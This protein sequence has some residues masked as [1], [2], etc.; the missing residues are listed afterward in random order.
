MKIFA[1]CLA[2]LLALISLAAAGLGIYIS[3]DKRGDLPFLVQ[4][5]PLAR[6]RV[7]TLFSSVK[8]G[9]YILAE[10]VILGQPSLGIDRPAKDPLAAAVWDAYQNSLKFEPLSDF[11]ATTY[12]LAVDYKMSRLDVTSVLEPVA[13]RAEANIQQRIAQAKSVEEI[14]DS[15]NEY[16]D[17]VVQKAVDMALA[18][19]LQEDASYMQLEFTVNLIYQD[20]NWWVKGEKA[21]MDALAA[22]FG[23]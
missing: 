15:N 20:G 6:Q 9:D 14:Y 17:D 16:R 5:S 12:G 4:T 23:G 8:K 21:L 19:A 18:A 7:E 13:A 11:Y 3:M 10:S 1:R 2:A 22:G